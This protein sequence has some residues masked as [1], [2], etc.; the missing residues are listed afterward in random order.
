M[1]WTFFWLTIRIW[2]LQTDYTLT[3]TKYTETT[4]WRTDADAEVICVFD[5]V[6]HQIGASAKPDSGFK[7]YCHRCMH[8]RSKRKSNHIN[9]HPGKR[10][11]TLELKEPTRLK[12]ICFNGKRLQRTMH[13][14]QLQQRKWNQTLRIPDRRQ[15]HGDTL[16]YL[17]TPTRYATVP[18]HHQSAIDLA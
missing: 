10:T 1:T 3:T 7:N 18:S 2:N 8:E 4:D 17:D 11:S 14:L 12:Y 16:N 15:H 6:L 9:L 5:K 13:F